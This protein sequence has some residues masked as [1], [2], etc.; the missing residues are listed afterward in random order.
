MGLWA[1]PLCPRIHPKLCPTAHVSTDQLILLPFR[2]GEP[3]GENFQMQRINF[4]FMQKFDVDGNTFAFM[5]TSY[6]YIIFN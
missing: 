4:G 1:G 3:R 5:F 2:Q 6:L